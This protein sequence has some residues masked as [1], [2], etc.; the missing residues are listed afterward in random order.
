MS[1]CGNPSPIK[2]I[3]LRYFALIHGSHCISVVFGG[4][5]P[6]FTAPS[7]PGESDKELLVNTH[8]TVFKEQVKYV[9]YSTVQYS[10]HH[11]QASLIKS[12]WSTNNS[13]SLM[14]RWALR[15]DKYSTQQH[16]TVPGIPELFFPELSKIPR[17]IDGHSNLEH[18]GM[19]LFF[20]PSYGLRRGL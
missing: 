5:Y 1:Q 20:L 2:I 13:H 19:K 12:C 18:W 17:E 9:Q 8:L 7:L 16:T 11:C 4:P 15:V 10:I 14:S 6:G 3:R